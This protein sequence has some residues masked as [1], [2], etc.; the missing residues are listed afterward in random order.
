[1]RSIR[2]PVSSGP[3]RLADAKP[4]YSQLKLRARSFRL[5]DGAGERLHR[6]L[7]RHEADAEQARGEI[8]HRH[9]GPQE[10]QHE[11][12]EHRARAENQRRRVT[13]AI[14]HAPGGHREHRGQRRIE[15]DHRADDERRGALI[16]RE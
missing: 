10:R 5:R 12:D 16:H 3:V 4:S 8:K 7:Q 1:M 15:R 2:N 11:R 14:D 9:R 13:E 6:E